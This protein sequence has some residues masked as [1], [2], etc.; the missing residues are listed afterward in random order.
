MNCPKC[1]TKLTVQETRV[2]GD[3][4]IRRRLCPVCRALYYTRETVIS[5]E[6]GLAFMSQWKA[7]KRLKND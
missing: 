1:K 6:M 2:V 7:L 4:V 5:Y 3:V